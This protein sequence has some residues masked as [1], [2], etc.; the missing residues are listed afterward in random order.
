M[1][2]LL[3]RLCVAL[4]ATLV[5]S[6]ANAAG[7]KPPPPLKSDPRIRIENYQRDKIVTLY[8]YF[9]FVT[10]VELEG[11]E[12]IDEK[13]SSLG[14][15]GPWEVRQLGNKFTVK[16]K[17]DMKTKGLDGK[18]VEVP[19]P[20]NVDS[21][22]VII[23]N[24]RTYLFTLKC[25]NRCVA[26]S[27]EAKGMT[28]VLRF[29]FPN[30]NSDVPRVRNYRYTAQSMQNT[31]GDDPAEVYDDGTFTFLRFYKQQELPVVF[32]WNADDTES[33]VDTSV[34]HGD[35]I[36]IP[37]VLMRFVLRKGMAYATVIRREDPLER[38]LPV[39][40]PGT[41]VPGMEKEVRKPK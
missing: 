19:F 30:G 29:N 31:E 11:D 16:P 2:N 25:A 3:K 27:A 21:N 36:V 38:T 18:E 28:Y 24:K 17:W 37:R 10:V 20:L 12:E 41:T 1:R 35:T 7:E 22:A 13:S 6:A 26:A 14:F 8:G 5:L 34:Q 9:G 15:I 32:I 4:L 33:S 23:T 39:S 40:Y